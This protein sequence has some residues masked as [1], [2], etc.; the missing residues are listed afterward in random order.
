MLLSF[1]VP[2]CKCNW[3][4]LIN[5]KQS[6]LTYGHASYTM[7]SLFSERM[8]V[9][10][11]WKSFI[12]YLHFNIYVRNGK[13]IEMV[14]KNI[15]I[16]GNSLFA[17]SGLSLLSFR[18]PEL[19]VLLAPVYSV[20]KKDERFTHRSS[21]AVFFKVKCSVPFQTWAPGPCWISLSQVR[22]LGGKLL[23]K[24]CHHL[25]LSVYTLHVYVFV[26]LP[27]SLSFCLFPPLMSCFVWLGW[28]LLHW[29]LLSRDGLVTRRGNSTRAIVATECFHRCVS[30]HYL[31]CSL[32]KIG[33]FHNL[34]F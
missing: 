1:V 7:T 32:G 8:H 16:S 26:R 5:I 3:N 21:P 31:T 10:T 22:S 2:V 17:Y 6:H 11:L 4:M 24:L 28:E 34:T 18:E 27:L 15:H 12:N 20:W 25:T 13:E 23:T 14:S 29:H 9:V 19:G 33:L 30:L